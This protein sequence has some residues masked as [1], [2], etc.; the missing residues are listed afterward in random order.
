MHKFQNLQSVS[1]ISFTNGDSHW[2]CTVLVI[3]EQDYRQ[4]D[5]GDMFGCP[6]HSGSSG[7]RQAVSGSRNI[8]AYAVTYTGGASIRLILGK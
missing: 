8:L 6:R 3:V 5:L 4:H 1:S 2:K 7:G